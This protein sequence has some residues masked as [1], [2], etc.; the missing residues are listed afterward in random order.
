MFKEKG[1]IE[2]AEKDEETWNETMRLISESIREANSDDSYEVDYY[3][4][5]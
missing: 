3:K 4:N 5:T 2:I 1:F